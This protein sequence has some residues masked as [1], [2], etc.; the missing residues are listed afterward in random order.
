MKSVDRQRTSRVAGLWT[1]EFELP[2]FRW[3]TRADGVGQRRRNFA[4]Q[5][6]G[7]A[8]EAK[9]QQACNLEERVDQRGRSTT[10]DDHGRRDA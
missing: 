2:R 1:R 3:A 7:L 6:E 9:L 10:T 5:P 4:Q 8:A